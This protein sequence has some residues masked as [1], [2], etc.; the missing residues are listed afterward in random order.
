M[1][2]GAAFLAAA[3]AAPRRGPLTAFADKVDVTCLRSPARVMRLEDPDGVGGQ[4]PLGLGAAMQQWVTDKII[5]KLLIPFRI[6][7]VE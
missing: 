4:K 6:C 7:F 3:D 1:V 5:A 2:F